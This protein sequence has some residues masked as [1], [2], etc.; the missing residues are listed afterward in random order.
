MTHQSPEILTT[1]P[2]ELDPSNIM[3]TVRI[4]P[5]SSVADE[6]MA[7]YNEAI[8]KSRPKALYRAAYIESHNGD[9]IVIDGISFTSR[10]LC[11]NLGG[12]ERVFP[13]VAT[14]GT[15]L[16]DIVN[17]CDDLLKK[18][19]LDAIKAALLNC[20]LQHLYSHLERAYATGKV[21]HMSP[22]SGDT[23]IWPLKQQKELFSLL[24][25]VHAAIGVEL[26]DSYLMIPNKTVSGITYPSQVDFHT[27]Q[28]CHRENCPSRRA[29]FDANLWMYLHD[30]DK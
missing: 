14:C 16:E 22:G 30:S 7:L 5:G 13:Y 8:Q 19:W 27:C 15:E 11:K 23:N 21:A 28:L 26:T 20:S 24:G 3:K 1:F 10:T 4:R 18:Y 29:P 9:S 12:V 6:F 25:D 17:T 2:F